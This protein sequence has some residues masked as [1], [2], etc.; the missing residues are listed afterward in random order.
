[1]I[2]N[3]NAPGKTPGNEQ[4]PNRFWKPEMAERRVISDDKPYRILVVDDEPAIRR[5][6]SDLLMEAGYE[7]DAVGNGVMAWEVLNQNHYDLL[8]TDNLM[9][10]MSGVELLKKLHA[11]HRFLPVIMATGTLPVEEIK[12]EPWFSMT[13]ILLKPYTLQELIETVKNSLRSTSRV[14][15]AA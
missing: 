15:F 12:C 1:M 3:V 13:T 6:N 5:L 7:V 11:C 2:A 8:I 4:V 14:R 9:P 10:K